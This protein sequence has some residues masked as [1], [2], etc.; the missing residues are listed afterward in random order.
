VYFMPPYVTTPQEIDL[1][2][3]VAAA[4]IRHAVS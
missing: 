1:M 4:S 2:I 3:D